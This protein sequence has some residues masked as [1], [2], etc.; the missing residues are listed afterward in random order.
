VAE[1]LARLDPAVQVSRPTRLGLAFGHREGLAEVFAA[2]I[3][4]AVRYNDKP[5]RRVKIGSRP[6]E[7]TRYYVGDNGPGVAAENRDLIFQP[8]GRL[9][10]TSA[11]AGVGLA[12][13]RKI[14]ERHGGRLWFEPTPGEGATFVFTLAPETTA[15]A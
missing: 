8:F 9:G 11:G 6:G 7:P 2:L 13:A 14:V 1:S 4:N 3:D 12:F 15:A 5:A 10:E